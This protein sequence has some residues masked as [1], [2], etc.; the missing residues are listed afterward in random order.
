MAKKKEVVIETSSTDT[1]IEIPEVVIAEANDKIEVVT[2]GKTYVQW[3][4]SQGVTYKE[5]K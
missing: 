3:I 5:L 4:D 2:D 1:V